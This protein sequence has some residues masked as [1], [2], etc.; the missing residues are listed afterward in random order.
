MPVS[1]ASEYAAV[2]CKLLRSR[3]TSANL[4]RHC[5]VYMQFENSAGCFSR[6]QIHV[7]QLVVIALHHWAAFLLNKFTALFRSRAWHDQ[8]GHKCYRQRTFRVNRHAWTNRGNRLTQ[9][10]RLIRLLARRESGTILSEF[11]IPLLQLAIELTDIGPSSPAQSHQG[12][13]YNG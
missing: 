5:Q 4:V 12:P 3:T 9:H 11:S 6:R 10:I 2:L 1:V 8:T 13:Q 7:Y